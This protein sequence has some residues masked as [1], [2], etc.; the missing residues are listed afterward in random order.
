[1]ANY[2]KYTGLKHK[3]PSFPLW[4]NNYQHKTDLYWERLSLLDG[5]WLV[6]IVKYAK[7]DTC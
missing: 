5:S 7:S 2:I 4:Y 6:K 3:I 1:M